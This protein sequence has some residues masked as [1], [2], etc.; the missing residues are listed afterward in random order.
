VEALLTSITL[1]HTQTTLTGTR[2]LVTL[3]GQLV[4]P[5]AGRTGVLALAV[6]K[7]EA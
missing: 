1:V 7:E 6:L 5:K 2:T 4:G 3:V